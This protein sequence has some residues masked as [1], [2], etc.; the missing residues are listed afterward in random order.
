M[1][2]ALNGP[3]HAIFFLQGYAP[4]GR[5]HS[6]AIEHH[7]VVLMM[8]RFVMISSLSLNCLFTPWNQL[9]AA[10]SLS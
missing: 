9:T 5:W 1:T 10:A 3:N 2:Q 8:T 6:H 7:L 4:G